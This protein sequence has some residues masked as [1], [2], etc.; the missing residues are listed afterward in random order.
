MRGT[1]LLMCKEKGVET[2]VD[3]NDVVSMLDRDFEV[4]YRQ[5]QSRSTE[6]FEKC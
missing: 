2:L 6:L 4:M 1:F 3:G 5:Y